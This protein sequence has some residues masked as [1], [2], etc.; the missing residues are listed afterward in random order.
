MSQRLHWHEAL[1][2]LTQIVDFAR[3]DGRPPEE[4]PGGDD[5]EVSHDLICRRVNVPAVTRCERQAWRLAERSRRGANEV[6]NGRPRVSGRVPRR[7][8]T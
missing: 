8:R 2:R 5:L 1:P 6:V 3:A 7:Q 4:N